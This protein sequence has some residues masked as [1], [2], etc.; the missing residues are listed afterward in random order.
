V[1]TVTIPPSQNYVEEALGPGGHE[2]LLGDG[3]NATTT[4]VNKL[5]LWDIP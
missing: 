3:W 5:Y 4:S 2:L 1:T